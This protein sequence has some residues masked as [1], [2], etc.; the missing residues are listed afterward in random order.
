METSGSVFKQIFS[1]KMLI[2]L[3]MGFS[4][5]LPLLITWSTIQAWLKE[6]NVDLGTIGLLTL[7][8]LPYTWKFVWSPIFDRYS[9]PFLGRRRGW[10]IASQI[11]LTI[12][13]AML[14]FTNPASIIILTIIAAV[15]VAFFSASQDIIID[16]Y[17]RE[18]LTDEELGL[19]STMYVYGYRVAMLISGGGAM[20]MADHMSW[21]FVF[22]IL[23]ICMVPGILT[24]L[25]CPEPKLEAS[26]PK[27]LKES[28]VEPFKEFFK[29]DGAILILLFILLYK[30]GDTMAGAMTLPFYLEVGFT[31]TQVGL[32]TK[33]WGLFATLFG[34]F[35]G[36]SLI[37]KLG[38]SKSLW[39]F[40]GLQALSTAG[41]AFLASVGNSVP[42]L[43]GVIAFE[44]ISA[45]MGT[46]AFMAYMATQTD[47]RFTATQYALLTSL[48][49]VPRSLLSAPT[50]YMVESMGW[51]S[52]FIFCTLIAIPGV[53]LLMKLAPWNTKIEAQPA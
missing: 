26:T 28:V 31:K 15:A 39:I 23:A 37:L 12:S 43:T 38:I 30:V 13:I 40:G 35:V 14:G 10:L 16:A 19:G 34:A 33:G 25:W 6:S 52:F 20:I 50:G 5:G 48:M 32:I 1:K 51:Q 18:Y 8:Q 24:T 41:F 45:G 4:S 36:G 9:L 47:K 27:T 49:G 3:L 42:V 2:C 53:L 17:R 46:A 11:A 7:V 29:R 21:S 22:I 44:N